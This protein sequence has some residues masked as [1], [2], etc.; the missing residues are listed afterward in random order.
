MQVMSLVTNP[1]SS[2]FS[3]FLLL[4]EVPEDQE[5]AERAKNTHHKLK[6]PYLVH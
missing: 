1:G 2:S 6:S 4:A 3:P 5:E